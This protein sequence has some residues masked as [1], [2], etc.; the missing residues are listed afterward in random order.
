VQSGLMDTERPSSGL[1]GFRCFREDY[2]Q[3][4]H[5][6]EKLRPCHNSCGTRAVVEGLFMGIVLA[7][8]SLTALRS[9]DRWAGIS[10]AYAVWNLFNTWYSRTQPGSALFVITAFVWGF[11]KFFPKNCGTGLTYRCDTG[12]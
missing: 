4:S 1:L 8:V 11:R 10:G 3:F 12:D 9:G 5:M 6:Q 7:S 2:S